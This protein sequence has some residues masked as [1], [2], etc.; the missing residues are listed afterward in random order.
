MKYLIVSALSF[1]LGMLVMWSMR[2]EP[3][4]Q[5]EAGMQPAN[6]TAKKAAEKP[7]G[8]R[9]MHQPDVQKLTGDWRD[10]TPPQV[11]AM[12]QQMQVYTDHLQQ[13]NADLKTRLD[14]AKEARKQQEGE[15][16]PWKEDADE[17]LHKDT[18][19]GAL[20]EAMKEAG[21]T[22]NISDIDCS[23]YP[24]T[25]AGTMQGAMG[26]EV[27][28]QLLDTPAMKAYGKD[29]RLT[30]MS[31]KRVTDENGN[32]KR[33]NVFGISVYNA[34]DDAE[35]DAIKKRAGYRLQSLMEAMEP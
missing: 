8:D 13:E 9:E 34:K 1:A 11:L 2:E 21:I 19:A 33:V 31:S 10:Q 27:F 22:G 6:I 25:M 24:C 20:D 35:A 14:W 7:R 32:E 29:Q 26:P 18:L 5:P 15:A 30:M 4:Q 12:I 16:I 23:E 17:R 28:K 3:A